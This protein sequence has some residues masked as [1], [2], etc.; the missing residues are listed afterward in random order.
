MRARMTSPDQLTLPRQAMEALGNP[1]QFDVQVEAGRLILV[2]SFPDPAD[3]VR[4]KLELLGLGE[5]DVA[6][7]VAWGRNQG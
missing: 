3:A 5:S 6:Q 1:S 7:A 2:P 4:R